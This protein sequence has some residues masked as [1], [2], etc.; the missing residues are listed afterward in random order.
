[1]SKKVAHFYDFGPYRVDAS[2]R[3]LLREGEPVPLTSKVF[4]TLFMLVSR[5]GEVLEKNELMTALWPDRFV[6][7]NNLTQN[8]SVLRKALGENR[9]EHRY[10]VTIPGRGYS[11]VAPVREV[12]AG[13]PDAGPFSSITEGAGI[14]AVGHA[15]NA[16]EPANGE[17]AYA[18][19]RNGE[20]QAK[21]ALQPNGRTPLLAVAAQSR[22][23][24]SR[25][26]GFLALSV[27]LLLVVPVAALSYL[28]MLR[29]PVGTAQPA[30]PGSIAV[31]PF[32]LLGNEASDEYLGSGMADALITKLSN[33]RQISVRPTSAVIKYAARPDTDP[34]AAGRELGVDS[35]LEGTIQRS[36]DRVR[37]TVQLT[38][39]RESKPLW[40]HSFDERFT[41][42]FTVQDSISAQVAQA[43]MLK[44]SGEEQRLLAKRYTDN[45]EA[46]QSYLRG[47]YFLSKRNEEGL[48]RAIAYF[49]D[50]IEK[51]PDYALAYAGLADA[52]SVLGFYEFGTLSP[53]ENYQRG[54]AAAMRALELDETL[55]EAHTS[56]ALAKVDVEHDAAGAEREYKRAIELNPGYATAHH[57]YSDFLAA[58]DRPEEAMAEIR[59]AIELDPLSLVINVTLGERLFYTRRYDEA[60]VQLHK[61]LELDESFG[62]THYL[63]GLT[64]EQKGMYEEA[65]ASFNRARE[66]SGDSPF[67]TAA[68]GHTFAVSGKRSE[69]QKLL[70]ELKELSG[71]RKVSP[72]DIATIYTGL[73][74]RTQAFEWLQKLYKTQTRHM[75]KSDPRMDSLRP[76]PR[77]Q[78]L[79]SS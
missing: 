4:D 60:L 53:E 28:W 3:L 24:Q 38:S 46:Y 47:R 78:E 1:M 66:L 43:L 9:S 70:V 14:L 26:R 37:V 39:V 18:F 68:L 69:A 11:F 61:T 67:I 33:I 27:I 54:R 42:I 35:V 64:L 5:S 49:A 20:H 55:A 7:E 62:L 22:K 17:E 52:Y 77:Y 73:G 12:C 25:R 32:K 74:E 56:L 48:R 40:A 16:L 13:E 21:Q 50:A 58:M 59:R 57:W 15:G 23:R 41:D 10:I 31:L 36:G 2:K 71:R 30:A 29:R 75:L 76:D 63:L 34:L 65:I 51:E 44:L 79:L 72:Y 19:G 6:E 8:I 45:V